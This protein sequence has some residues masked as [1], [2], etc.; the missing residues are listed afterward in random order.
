MRGSPKA[1][2]SS[3]RE[4]I[5]KKNIGKE[6][7][8]STLPRKGT[9]YTKKE[10][11]TTGTGSGSG[12]RKVTTLPRNRDNFSGDSETSD[13][14]DVADTSMDYVE[15]S[16]QTLPRSYKAEMIKTEWQELME[17]STAALDNSDM[18]HTLPKSYCPLRAETED[19]N[20][21]VRQVLTVQEKLDVLDA[22]PPVGF[23][24]NE[25][26]KTSPRGFRH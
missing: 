22:P 4:L 8:A 16:S 3:V 24:S 21:E 11:G 5:E 10:S 2:I 15:F 6:E 17:S 13:T 25:F 20:P 14:W 19:G 12:G 7:K 26:Q 1:S 18:F 23:A 9:I